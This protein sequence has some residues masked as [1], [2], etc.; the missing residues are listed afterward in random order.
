MA[1][2]VSN[3]LG[4]ILSE[5][6]DKILSE[7]VPQLIAGAKHRPDAV[8]EAELRDQARQFLYA[9]REALERGAESDVHAPEW[10]AMREMLDQLSNA[11]VQRGFTPTETAVLV[12]SLKRTLFE[13]CGPLTRTTPR[14][15][16]TRCGR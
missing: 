2:P 6:G 1:Q 13:Y 16:A 12:F 7:W 9:L 5:H 14:F 8:G 15:S 3:Q 4:A 11:R 10:S